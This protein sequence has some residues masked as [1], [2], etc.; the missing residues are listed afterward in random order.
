ME[1]FEILIIFLI[2]LNVIFL[3]AIILLWRRVSLFF[4]NRKTN[5][6]EEMMKSLL[7]ESKQ[8]SKKSQDFEKVIKNLEKLSKK[9][10]IKASLIRFNALG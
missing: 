2:C 4:K 10:L 1:L 9:N 5:N 6:M 3:V 8:L 7:E